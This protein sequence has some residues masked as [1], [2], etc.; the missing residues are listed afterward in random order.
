MLAEECGQWEATEVF[1][2]EEDVMRPVKILC[3]CW[4]LRGRLVQE[5][6]ERGMRVGNEEQHLNHLPS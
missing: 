5:G 2:G 3:G 6:W 4:V 1:G